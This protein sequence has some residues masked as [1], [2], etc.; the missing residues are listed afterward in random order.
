MT[1]PP[2][3]V[4]TPEGRMYVHP[5]TGEAVYSVTTIIDR[6]IPK[7]LADWAARQA[8]KYAVEHWHE[9]TLKPEAERIRLISQAHERARLKAAGRGDVIHASAEA[10]VKGTPDGKSPHHM[11]Q[12][13]D[14]F[15]VSGYRPAYTEVT[16]WHRTMEY[17]GTADLIVLDRTD[18]HILIDYKTGRGIWPEMA[19]QVEALARAEFIITEK[20]EEIPLPHIEEVGVLHL[21][22][23]SWWYHPVTGEDAAERN[24]S[25][26]LGAKQIS[27]WRRLH[28]DLVW[29]SKQRYNASNWPSAA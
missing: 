14:F 26:F 6:G 7:E 15:K 17:A 16:V 18:R 4:E 23:K 28:P 11:G 20:G 29:G 24:W 5:I 1:H 12:L 13:E 10:Q 9:L 21:R 25:A 22:P 2:L 3:A 27:D 8:A 19:V